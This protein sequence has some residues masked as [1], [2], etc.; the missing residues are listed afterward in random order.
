MIAL[1]READFAMLAW[2]DDGPLD[3]EAR[4][5]SAPRHVHL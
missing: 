4:T 2:E 1:D 3:C 5:L